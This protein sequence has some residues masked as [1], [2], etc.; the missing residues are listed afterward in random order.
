MTKLT[1][2]FRAE[3]LT[4]REGVYGRSQAT[5][6]ILSGDD[7]SLVNVFLDKVF[8]S[9]IIANRQGYTLDLKCAILFDPE[10]VNSGMGKLHN[11]NA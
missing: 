8:T 2:Q 5:G 4:L 3:C 1:G 9:C 6:N 11:H 7:V 10:E